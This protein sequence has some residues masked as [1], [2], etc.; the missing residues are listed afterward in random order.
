VSL[1]DD[2]E[3]A[4]ESATRALP[5]GEVREGQITMTRAVAEA[6]DTKRHLVVQAGTGTGKSLAYLVPAVLSGKR[7]VVATATKALQDQLVGKDLPFL[8]S[9]LDRGFTFTCLKGRSNYLCLQ[10][11]REAGGGEQRMVELEADHEVNRLIS[12]ASDQLDAGGTG[13][14]AELAFEPAPAAWAA[15]SVSS[16]ECPGAG[17]CP[18]GEVCF[19]E[20]ARDE[21]ALAD[22]VVVNS[23]LYGT[24]L[25]AESAV[26][27]E[28]DVV[29][30]D[31]AHVLADV[32]SATAGLEIMASRF[33]A[34]AVALRGILAEEEQPAAVADA[35]SR[36]SDA[37]FPLERQRIKTFD[38]ELADVFTLGRTR[39][40]IA[41]GALRR[42]AEPTPEV[43]TRKERAVRLTSSL[44][45]DLDAIVDLTPSSVVWVESGHGAAGHPVL[46]QAP[47]DVRPELAGLFDLD[48]VVL[49]SAT[50]NEQLAGQLGMPADRSR[51]LGVGSP[52]DFRTNA[53]L[54]CARHLPD[55][56]SPDFEAAMHDELA[57]LIEAAGGRTLALFT[58]W[59]RM[60]AAV[61]AVRTK[62]AFP[63]LAQG[64]LPK[65]A[66]V[67]RFAGDEATCLFATMGFWQGIDVPGRSLSLV[68]IDRLP[69]TPPDD[70]LTQAR[71]EAAGPAAF[72]L[73]DLPR[74]ATFLAQ[75]SGRLIRTATDRGVVAV[76]DRRLATMGYRRKILVALPPMRRVVDPTE[77]RS[78]LRTITTR[79]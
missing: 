72:E 26:L 30:I 49:T 36:L 62:V 31:E 79:S 20:R 9:A 74:A 45:D 53:R 8:A 28:H 38:G 11:A 64:E 50:V 33:A 59:S 24:H 37:L 54:Y 1:A 68:T 71:R 34:V 56:R 77:A 10:R 60:R 47:V 22:V 40:E 67:A 75:G 23:Y 7:V 2:A 27:T 51:F 16:R 5:G 63:V 70:P 41:L 46:R 44:I 57:G 17:R 66:L 42:I 19:A 76:F 21:A 58:S 65:P 14:R 25:A 3:A 15:V 61:A 29:V 13:D 4:L 52:F 18:S 32:I 55:P 78:F 12:W 43:A 6:I 73:I 69:F 39:L 35:G 48:S